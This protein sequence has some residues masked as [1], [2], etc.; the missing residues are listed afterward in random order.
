MST[1]KVNLKNA[2]EAIAA[3][4][5]DDALKCVQKVLDS[6]PENYMGLVFAGITYQNLGQATK[7]EESFKKAISTTPDQQLAYEGL[8]S[9]YEKLQRWPDLMTALEEILNI[10][11][12]VPDGKKALAT[13]E[14]LI[15]LYTSH[16]EVDKAVGKIQT[17][18]E[19]SSLFDILDDKPD[20]LDTLKRL[21]SSQEQ[22][23]SEFYEREVKQRRG[24]LGSGTQQQVQTAVR[25][26]LYNKSQLDSTYEAILE[27]EP[28]RNMELQLKLLQFYTNKMGAVSQGQK[29]DVCKK[30]LALATDMIQHNSPSPLPYELILKF[31]DATSPSDYDANLQEQY[32]TQFP[33]TGLSKMIQAQ[34]RYANGESR[35][36]LVD[37][38]DQGINMEPDMA[39]GYL[40]I[41]WMDHASKDYE[42]GLE[43]ATMGRDTLRE[44]AAA[45]GFLFPN[46]LRSFELCMADCQLN[47]SPKLAENALALYEGILK[48]D[49]NNIQAL[50]GVGF[51]RCL[52]KKFKEATETFQRVHE[53]DPTKVSAISEL[54]WICYLQQD[55]EH[56]EEKLR[57]VIEMSE[58]HRALDLYRL[59]RIYYDMGA[60]YRDNPDYSHAQLIA[61]A[62]LDP[63]CAGAFTYLGHYY[64]EVVQDATRAEKCYQHAFSLD[65][66]EGDA[67]RFLSDFLLDAGSLEGAI[68]VYQRVIEADSKANWAMTRLGFA[69]LM[70]GNNIEA[71]GSFQ[72]LLRNDIKCALAWEG[73][74]EAYLHEGR[75]MAALKAFTRNQELVPDSTTAVYHIAHVHQR[76]GMYPEAIEHYQSALRLAEKN[77]EACH[78]PS[79]MGMAE[80]YLEQGKEDFVSGY[81]G[82]SAESSG[83]ALVYALQLLQNDATPVSA[84]KLVGDACLAYRAVPRY[85]HLCPFET[86]LAIVSL[87]P[88]DINTL[89]HF[90]AGLE[91]DQLD[92]IKDTSASLLD[93]PTT[94]AT[95]R[96]LD[97]I[98][99]VAGLAYKKANIL[100][101]NQ[102]HHAAQCWYDIALTYYYRH[103]NALKRSDSQGVCPGGQW[104]GITIRCLKASL[105][106]EEENPL[107]WNALGVATLSQNAKISQH[108][109]IKAIEYDSKS[110][111]AWSNLGFLYLVHSEPDLA[112]KAFTTAQTL[113]PSFAQAWAGQACVASL[114]ASHEA[115]ALFAH[116]FESSTASVL[117]ANYGYAVNTFT[118]MLANSHR[119]ST[120]AGALNQNKRG[121]S[122]N[123]TTLLV[124]PTFAILKYLEQRPRDIQAWN[125]LGLIR[126]RFLQQEGAAECFL[127]AIN[128]LNDEQKDSD[129]GDEHKRKRMI[130]HHN[131]ARALLSMQDYHGSVEAFELS[132]ELEG[133]EPTPNVVR[134]C[135][136]LG[137][138]LALYYAGELER[139]LTMFE[140]ALAE[141]EQVEGM[142]QSRDDVVVLLSQVLWA[143][144]GEEQQAAAKEELF[145]CIA[146][147]P[148]HL[149]AIFGLGAM[150]LVQ[151]DET[152]ATAALKEIL[153]FSRQELAS[154]DPEMRSD[155]MISQYYSLLS[156]SKLSMAA[157]SKSVHQAPAEAA[158]WRRLS[159]YL[160][161][162]ISSTGM[163]AYSV[164]QSN[165]KA[166]LDLLKQQESL[167]AA[168]LM[169]G[170]VQVAGTLMLAD[171]ERRQKVA[172]WKNVKKEKLEE[173]DR[174][175][176]A[177]IQEALTMAQ[178]A[179]MAAPWKRE[180]WQVV[181]T[182][183][184]EQ[185]ARVS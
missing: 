150:G 92:V 172:G 161:T 176:T 163:C 86:L 51:V 27:L 113:D 103:E 28:H 19:G 134:T 152:L 98:Y 156:E 61:A 118:D 35:D 60:E 33:S 99:A 6:D 115:T 183:V 11:L 175:S 34:L 31:T 68:D 133:P 62:R 165:A 2:R 18:L 106:F 8:C 101:G 179:A 107:V 131:L 64:R 127:T 122:M 25:N 177:R 70:R 13:T 56:A 53:L 129:G 88:S 4:N 32:I 40:A 171:E 90:P 55:Y 178:R 38:L 75:Y 144:G 162:T 132:L 71:M 47:I 116:A 174:Q 48:A 96:I 141:T 108:A 119:S 76:L 128:I 184:Q 44:L 185:S 169:R 59:G 146:Q 148:T 54:G 182:V 7:G 67:G 83:Q 126:E 24:R 170:Y 37:I 135:K 49:K 112:L 91:D 110:V 46:M 82:R 10:Q 100:N 45:T 157:L 139:S 151:D 57:Q 153:K 104:L 124:T 109:F 74:A 21:A 58:S 85:L 180:A 81:Y 102:G 159:E 105:Q 167:Q 145:R 26:E 3:K 42:S 125:L 123:P 5:Y 164:T 63:Q 166:A 16:D 155:R 181:G 138:G 41:C 80:S 79:L 77:Q 97:A 137:A 149:P 20:R 50:E 94:E 89:L 30:T 95:L 9:F 173:E 121:P 160:S 69:E 73:V 111:V 43:H 140:T 39:Y 117:E 142:E 29:A 78:I 23:D 93:N 158:L 12:R 1:V 114:W 72:K 84:W 143:L 154:M 147:S 36:D 120:G 14:K 66:R 136:H 22:A 65:P 130:L 168:D 52:E 15:A 17:L 87:L